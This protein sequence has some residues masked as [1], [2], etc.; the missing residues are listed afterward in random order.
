[1]F[2]I[3]DSFWGWVGVVI[4]ILIIMGLADFLLLS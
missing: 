1:M 3:F 4:F 2:D